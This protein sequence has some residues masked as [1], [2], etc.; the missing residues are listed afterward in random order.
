MENASGD[1]NAMVPNAALRL[2]SLGSEASSSFVWRLRIQT[3]WKQE[4][5][6]GQVQEAYLHRPL[7]KTHLLGGGWWGG[8]HGAGFHFHRF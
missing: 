4:N 3:L 2:V 6:R 7:I 8:H 5:H 1:K